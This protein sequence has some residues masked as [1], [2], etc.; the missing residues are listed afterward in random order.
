M[1]EEE[2]DGVGESEAEAAEEQE[3]EQEDEER[4]SE[5]LLQELWKDCSGGGSVLPPAAQI[6][7][8]IRRGCHVF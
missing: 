6:K 1:S 7:H 2:R 3:P 4:V 5:T 8:H